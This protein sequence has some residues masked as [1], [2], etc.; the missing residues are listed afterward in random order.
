MATVVR[1]EVGPSTQ[2]DNAIDWYLTAVDTSSWPSVRHIGETGDGWTCPAGRQPV[3]T[4][5]WLARARRRLGL[6]AIVR[7]AGQRWTDAIVHP[8]GYSEGAGHSPDGIVL[9][10]T[11]GGS[12]V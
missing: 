7:F 3:S 10:W 6:P 4:D 8:L 5:G 11:I 1:L 2:V 9:T 12:H